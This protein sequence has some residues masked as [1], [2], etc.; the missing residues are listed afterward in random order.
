MRCYKLLSNLKLSGGFSASDFYFP[1]VFSMPSKRHLL[2]DKETNI[3]ITNPV[4]NTLDK[5][6]F[7]V[8]RMVDKFMIIGFIIVFA[9]FFL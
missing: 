2:L 1:N 7:I 6:N 5:F 4:K 8:K 3:I 9:G